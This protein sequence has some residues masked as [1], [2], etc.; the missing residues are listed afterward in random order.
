MSFSPHHT[1]TWTLFWVNF[2][3]MQGD[4]HTLQVLQ[5]RELNSVQAVF[6]YRWF[7]FISDLCD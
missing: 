1:V 5:G 4:L 2:F 7:F 3:L 6:V